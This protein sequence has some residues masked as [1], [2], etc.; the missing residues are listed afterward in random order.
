MIPWAVAREL[1]AT[2]L[3]YL[4][5]TWSIG[6]ADLERALFSFLAGPHGLFQGPYL[7]IGLPF[8][9]APEGAAMPLEILPPYAPHLHQLEAW[10]RLSSRARTPQAT[11]ITTGTGS[12]KTECFLYPVLDHAYREHAAGKAGIKAII[13]YPMNALASDQA[14]RFA[15]TIDGDE[16]LRG[17]LRVGLFI[18]GKGQHRE[19]GRAHVIDD[20]DRLRAQPP[21]ILLTNYRMLDLLLQRPKDAPLWKHN[22]PDT[23]RYLV[24]DELHTYD[25]A[26]GT[27]VACL[28]RR[29]GQRLGSAEALCPVGTSA[30]VGGGADTRTELLAF[31]ST[32]FDQVFPVDAFIGETRVEPRELLPSERLEE[33]YP[34]EPGPWPDGGETAE[35]HVKDVVRAWLSPAAQAEVL[36]TAVDG[37]GETL[38]RVALGRW[39]MR[40]PVA[41][42]LLSLAHRRPVLGA[43]VD[44]ALQKELPTFAAG[45]AAH[46]SGWL[47]AA[48]TMLS[49][50]QRDVS[51]HV[52]PLVSVQVTLWIREVRRLLSHVGQAP[53][54]R[55][56]DDAPPPEDEAWTPRYACRDC[57]HNGWLVTESGPGDLLGLSYAEI[58]RAFGERAASLR[59]VHDDASLADEQEQ[60]HGTPPR[61]A[62]LDM[63]TRRLL[64]KA[65][66]AACPRLFVHEPD[67]TKVQCPACGTPDAVRMIA[68]R[69]TTLSS[70]AVG[71]LFTTPLNTDQK[72][73]AFSDSV[74]DAA[75]RA[76]F[77]GARTF[78]FAVRTAILAGVPRDGAA[79]ALS[80]LP[81][82]TWQHWLPKTG[83]DDVSAEADLTARLLP[84]DMHWLAS[85]EE[86]HDRLDEHVRSQHRAE[87]AGE[88]PPRALPEPSPQLVSDVR[89]RLR[90]ECTRELG[91]ASRIGRTLEQSGCL[92]V[93]LERCRFEAAVADATTMLR[94]KVGLTETQTAEALRPFVAGLLTRLRLRG[95]VCDPLLDP[96]VASGGNTFLLS[97][98][99]APLLSPFGPATSRPL[100][101]TNAPKPRQFDSVCS[102]RLTSWTVDWVAR[103]LAPPADVGL[104]SEIYAALMPVL[105]RHGLVRAMTTDE[106]TPVQGGKATAWGLAPEALEVSRK[107]AVRKCDACG[108]ELAVVDGSVTDLRDRP[109]LR[110]RC[111]GRLREVASPVEVDASQSLPL[112]SYY[113]RFYERETLGRLW[114]REHTGLLERGARESLEL[115]F[116]QRPRPDSPNLLSCTPTLEMGIDIGDLSATLL[117]SV[118]P[119]TSQYVQRVGRAGRKTG[120]ALVLAFAAS[121]A[122]DLYFFQ[123]PLEAMAGVISPPGCYLSAPEVLKRQ[124]LAFLFDSFAKEGGKLEGRVREAL[125]GD[126]AKRFPQPLF[127]FVAPRRDKLRDAFLEL[128]RGELTGTALAK[129]SAAFDVGADGLSS[130]EHALASTTQA[131]RLRREELRGLVRKLDERLKQLASNEVEAKKVEDIEDEKRRLRDERAFVN[132]QLLGLLD[133]DLWGWLT[134]ESRLPNY[135]FPERG[136]KLDA[137]IR[138]EGVGSDPEHHTWVRAPSAALTELAPFNTFYAS[139]R[140][141]RIDGLEM[142]KEA[143]PARW[144]F[145]QCCHHAAAVMSAA[146]PE[147]TCPSCGDALWGDVGQA[148]DVLALGQV[149][150]IASHRDAVLGDDGDDRARQFYETVSLFEAESEADDAWSNDGAGFG[151]ELQRAMVLRQLNLGKRE[152][153]QRLHFTALAG[154]SVPDV[155]F[156]VCGTCGQAQDPD[157][158]HRRAGP[159]P[160]AHRAWCPER[161]KAADK[162]TPRALH[163]LRELKS[164]ALRM[165]VPFADGED[166]VADLANLRA[167]LRVGLRRFYGGD[168]DFLDV[169]TYDE[170]LSAREGR[171]RF[172][173]IMDRV[174]G[175]TGLLAEL[176]VNKGAKLKEAFEKAHDTLRACACQRREPP[177][178]ACYQ[179]L[180]A[181]R[182]GRDLA[183]LDRLRAL[184][185][186]EDA[187][188]AFD[189][190]T[191][192]ETIGTMTQSRVLESEL[193]ERFIRRLKDRVDDAR[194]EWL[195]EGEGRWRLRL[196]DRRWLVR[197]QVELKAD[198]VAVPCRADFVLFP[199]EQEAEARPVAIFTDGL[200][201]H[202]MPESAEARLGDD[203]RKRLGISQG[204][205][206]LSWS[207]TWKDVVSPEAPAVPKWFGDGAPFAE[208]QSM[209]TKLDA[210]PSTAPLTPLLRVLDADPLRALIEYLSAPTRLT[211][212]AA[213][214]CFALL[215]RGKRQSTGTIADA[216]EAWR[217][218]HHASDVA[219]L[220]SEGDNAV[221]QLRLGE[222]ARL[223]L[224][225]ERSKLA[226][227]VQNAAPIRATL[228]LEDG[229]AERRE[230]TFELSWRLWLRAWN[231]LQALPGAVALT[232]SQLT[233]GSSVRPVG[234]APQASTAPVPPAFEGRTAGARQ[235]I[236]DA[237]SEIADTG[238]ATAVATLLEKHPSLEPPTVPFELRPPAFGVTGDVELAFGTRK[239]A[240]YFD[241]ESAFASALRDAGWKVLPVE[242]GITAETLETALGLSSDR[243][244]GGEG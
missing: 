142:K 223:L 60:L 124:A 238:L 2:L 82:A 201:Y 189:A 5:S 91:L 47:A 234:P 68:A 118:P 42:A 181:Y 7:K 44:A 206:M 14:Q 75:H 205:S 242:S 109:C 56:F 224:D 87:Q 16:R 233:A 28:I 167:A 98:R 12:G 40:L 147:D 105:A 32:L 34:S 196:G 237:L 226:S 160:P 90:W 125:G 194:G 135:A 29:L 225:V 210:A 222:H 144:R 85:A 150:A 119:G 240:A 230:S 58:A 128:F 161:K 73:L 1:R 149:F 141:V 19:M 171:R 121:R 30:T 31:A 244:A 23:L 227:L 25:G 33:S 86:W 212:L 35:A 64:E 241:R 69:S 173:V 204:G 95:G 117:C 139:A 17:R 220:E 157:G 122:H 88:A 62:W 27:D 243:D 184:E 221:V 219:V 132:H 107:H 151:F 9:S 61:T 114:S 67:D 38:D 65:P 83:R 235:A 183:L 176:C 126:E 236:E 213:V 172:V 123:E 79:V 101:L 202:V 110:F 84:I 203:A 186:V 113:R 148:R 153:G 20:N 106:K 156:V 137:Y 6:S 100:F 116:K 21:D 215:H 143:P 66:D 200:A 207:L 193:E 37:S 191:K 54:F 127:D 74:Q 239:V 232:Q 18:G 102:P 229:P 158:E 15:E 115:E 187:M 146:P 46:R 103:C 214:S 57:G 178:K 49:F 208:L 180:Y 24:L 190:L 163:L 71:H 93:S 211:D 80:E 192:V 138:R 145:C 22:G 155:R 228:R 99:Q 81:E 92:S 188:G 195:Q 216:Q 52:M 10:Q 26:Q 182:E 78:R 197:A 97:K 43:D 13:L 175:G 129:M 185:I 104:A 168:P 170:P 77:Y 45:S 51:G 136:V 174:P 166:L 63:R 209:V 8:A 140:R 11:L 76:G 72:L 108:G 120:N 55:F 111:N 59:L 133:K 177:V 169:L 48:L 179:C 152:D 198:Q 165:V 162:Q 134:E 39:A 41:R 231:L 130:L 218:S 50:A 3:D 199:E 70:V 96:Y 89:A 53:A 154:Q 131:T 4:R 164:E 112:V 159:A 94:E 36:P 217:S